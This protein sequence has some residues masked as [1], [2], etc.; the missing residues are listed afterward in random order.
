MS[1]KLV[2]MNDTS[3]RFHHGCARVMRLLCKGLTD[4]GAKILATSPARHDWE[5]DQFF[6]AAVRDCDGVVINGEGTLHHGSKAG[7]RLLRIATHPASRGK[8]KFLVNALYDSNPD[9]WREF[10]SEFDL[11]MARDSDSA[12]QLS[13]AVSRTVE[14]LPDLSLSEAVEDN[15]KQRMGMIIGDSVRLERRRELAK[16][17]AIVEGGAY[18]PT[19]TL[20]HAI[21]R[22]PI[23][24]FALSNALFFVYNAYPNIRLGKIEMP[25]DEMSYIERIA[26]AELHITGRFHGVCFSL[27]T[28]TPFLALSS[29][30][31][32]VEKLL[33]DL[34]LGT[35]RMIDGNSLRGMSIDPGDFDF[36]SSELAIVRNS[37]SEARDKTSVFFD[38]LLDR[39]S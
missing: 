33:V 36:K 14:W 8:K 21:W 24:G 27:L 31:G 7:E 12:H 3:N 2:L 35:S 10:L 4:R 9:C 5:S 25:T 13:A 26:S 17:F 16:Y 1:I 22:T 18:V 32:K 6:L 20:T 37:L 34:N 39:C 23:L 15:I 11:L 28:E 30:S 29:N 38:Q 19:K